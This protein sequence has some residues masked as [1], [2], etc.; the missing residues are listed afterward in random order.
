MKVNKVKITIFIVKHKHNRV[1]MVIF[2]YV[3]FTKKV[4]GNFGKCTKN[5]LGHYI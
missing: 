4:F 1:L 5:S 2:E 3:S